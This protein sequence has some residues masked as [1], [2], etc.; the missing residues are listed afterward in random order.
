[1]SIDALAIQEKMTW[2]ELEEKLK[3][4]LEFYE[5][6]AGFDLIYEDNKPTNEPRK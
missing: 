6:T 2:Q 1:M 3:K 4:A 5:K